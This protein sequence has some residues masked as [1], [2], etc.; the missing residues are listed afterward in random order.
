MTGFKVTNLTLELLDEEK[1]RIFQVDEDGFMIC[2][3]GRCTKANVAEV[4]K[5]IMEISDS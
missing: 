3:N 2:I 1:P 4:E 5:S